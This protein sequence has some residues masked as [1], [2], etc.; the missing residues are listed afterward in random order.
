MAILNKNTY[1]KNEVTNWPVPNY[2][3]FLALILVFALLISLGMGAKAMLGKYHIGQ[4]IHISLSADKLPGY[5]LRSVLRMLIA[6]VL[7]F[8]F[9]FVFGALAAKSKQAER[10]IIPID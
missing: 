10:I 9:T 5:A 3:D 1:A 7:S 8:V 2:W 4:T 6:L